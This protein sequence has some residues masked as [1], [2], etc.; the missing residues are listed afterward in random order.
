MR[1][2]EGTMQMANRSLELARPEVRQVYSRPQ[3][4]RLH[5]RWQ[6]RVRNA[7]WNDD[8]AVSSMCV[9]GAASPAPVFAGAIVNGCCR[10]AHAFNVLVFAQRPLLGCPLS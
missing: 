2:T 7:V 10:K 8:T 1:A 5:R 6:V 4:H 9:C 3:P